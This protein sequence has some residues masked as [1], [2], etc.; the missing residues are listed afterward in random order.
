VSSD[1]LS[2][3]HKFYLNINAGKSGGGSLLLPIAQ[4]HFTHRFQTRSPFALT[5]DCAPLLRQSSASP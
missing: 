5:R 3:E 4:D 2:H 1:E